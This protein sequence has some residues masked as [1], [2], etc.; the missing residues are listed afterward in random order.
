MD[1][2]EYFS[3]HHLVVHKL[4]ASRRRTLCGERITDMLVARGR[5]IARSAKPNSKT[6]VA[7][8]YECVTGTDLRK[9][10]CVSI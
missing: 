8:C 7:T 10:P 6:L 4:R 2:T 5:D 1:F 3:H 9:V